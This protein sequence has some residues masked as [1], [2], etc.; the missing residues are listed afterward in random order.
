MR[1]VAR[2]KSDGS[3]TSR[4]DK[5]WGKGRFLVAGSGEICRLEAVLIDL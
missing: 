2:L 4:N 3:G 1:N 5:L